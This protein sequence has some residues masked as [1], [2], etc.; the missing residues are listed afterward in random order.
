MSRPTSGRRGSRTV[1]AV[2]TVLAGLTALLTT[3]TGAAR[4]DSTLTVTGLEA[5]PGVVRFLL[6]ARQLPRNAVL[7]PS[8]VTVTV[9][10]TAL[11]A[12][13]VAVSRSEGKLPPRAL[14]VVLDVSGS[15]AGERLAAARAAARALAT[16]LPADV[17]LGLVA[18]TGT[19]AVLLAPTDDRDAFTAA[20]DRLDARGDT[21]LYDG[22]L[23]G[24]DTLTGAGFGPDSDRRILVLSDGADTASQIPLS[25]LTGT[26][27]AAGVPTDVVAFRAAPA[28]L[29]N[30][31]TISRATGGNLLTAATSTALTN[32]FRAA[33]ATFSL[34]LAVEARVPNELARRD[35]DL[36]VAVTVAGTPLTTTVPVTL[37][38]PVDDPATTLSAPSR[39]WLPGWAIWAA[40]AGFFTSVLVLVLVLAWPRSGKEQRISQIDQFGPAGAP[41]SPVVP[42]A[43]VGTALTRTALAASESFVRSRNLETRIALRMEQAGLRLRPHEWVLLHGSAVV[44]GGALGVLAFGWL[45]LLAGPLAGWLAPRLYQSIRADRRSQQFAEQLPEALQLVGG[46]LRS[47]L[48]LGQALDAV[49]RESAEPISVEFGRA[50]AEHRLGADLPEAL[51]RVAERVRS[52]DLRWVVMAVRI[53]RDVGGNLAEVLQT[54]VETMRERSRLRRHVR[55]LSAEG[56]LS[57]YVLVGLPIVL[58]LFMFVFRREYMAPLVTDPLGIVMLLV[59]LVLLLVGMVWM[60][61]VVKVEV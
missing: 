35:G 28:G 52:E 9:G 37:A 50:L 49:V 55:S 34:V 51:E 58:G 32:T 3:T 23:L 21:A 46:S 42:T 54:A 45:G 10:D 59:G 31:R 7:D 18:V 4:A 61:R 38:G 15:V 40:V 44:T 26:L 41:R 39:P 5:A 30:L 22:V 47:G 36:R 53:Q 1:A 19:P 27:A 11:P 43:T 57:A 8:T 24:A 14:M 60:A 2:L 25:R 6:T 12:D 16:A 48:S 33:A 29:A 13:A 56:R 20:L 17:R